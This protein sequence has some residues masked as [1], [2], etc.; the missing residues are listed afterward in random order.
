M[1][2]DNMGME[3]LFLFTNRQPTFATAYATAYAKASVV[4]KSFGG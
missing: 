4:E 3:I 2:N 1:I